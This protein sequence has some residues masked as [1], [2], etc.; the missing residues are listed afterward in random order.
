MLQKHVQSEMA[1]TTLASGVLK[2]HGDRET[3]KNLMWSLSYSDSFGKKQNLKFFQVFFFFFSWNTFRINNLST[4][5]TAAP[6]QFYYKWF[7]Y[8]FFWVNRIPCRAQV[9]EIPLSCTFRCSPC[10]NKCDSTRQL[11]NSPSW[12]E[13][14]VL[15]QGK[16]QNVQHMGLSRTRD[17]KLQCI[18]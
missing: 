18:V 3:I 6:R 7:I 12:V 14:G 17:G 1:S 4:P 15:A 8:L 11:I 2:A 10:S 9:P 16:H 5:L 13:V